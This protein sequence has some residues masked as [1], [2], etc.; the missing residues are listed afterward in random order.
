MNNKVNESHD[1]RF[2]Q[3]QDYS[4]QSGFLHSEK[5]RNFKEDRGEDDNHVLKG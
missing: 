3:S 5:S 2:R 1:S 4:R